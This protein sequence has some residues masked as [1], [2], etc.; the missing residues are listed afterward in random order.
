MPVFRQRVGDGCKDGWRGHRLPNHHQPPPEKQIRPRGTEK[1]NEVANG[2][3]GEKRQKGFATPP[4]IRQ[5]STRVLV[6][7]IEKIFCRAKQSYDR[8]TR[9][10]RLQILGKK[11]LPKLLPQSHQKHRAGRRRNIALHSEPVCD[12]LSDAGTPLKMLLPPKLTVGRFVSVELV[13]EVAV[14]RCWPNCSERLFS[15]LRAKYS[16]RSRSAPEYRRN[17]CLISEALLCSPPRKAR[18]PHVRPQSM[19]RQRAASAPRS[20]PPRHR[21]NV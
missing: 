21:P 3:D 20:A 7:R 10:E 17:H 2:C 6:E 9:T 13:G 11:L 1:V 19:S 16:R 4:I 12:S 8:H 14:T 18:L 5:P 15:A